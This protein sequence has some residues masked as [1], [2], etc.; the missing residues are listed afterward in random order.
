M[1]ASHY[2]RALE[3]ARAAGR[4]DVELVARARR[5]LREAGERAVSLWAWPAAARFFEDALELWPD[6]DPELGYIRLE[7]GR[8]RFNVDG[9]G[10]ELV[11]EGAEELIEAGDPELAARAAVT[12]GRLHWMVGDVE[13]QNRFLER[14]LALVGD[15]RDS[16]AWVAARTSQVAKTGFDG[17]F[18][19]AIELGSDVLLAAER[20]G[21]NDFRVRLLNL[22]GDARLALGDEGGFEDLA[23]SIAVATET[24]AHEHLHS[25]LNNLLAR[26]INLGRAKDARETY[27]RMQENLERY[28]AEAERRWVHGVGVE[29]AFSSGNWREASTLAD[30]YLA[31][32]DVSPSYLDPIVRRLRAVLRGTR[33]DLAGALDDS[34]KALED[35]RRS[36]DGQLVG[37]TL[38]GHAAILLLDRRTADAAAL[39]RE[40]LELENLVLNDFTL[41]DAAWTMHDVGLA[42]PFGAWLD[43]GPDLPWSRAARLILADD[44]LAAAEL[45]NEIYVPGEAYAR[46]RA[47]RQLV[48]GGRRAEADVELQRALAF[49]REVGATLYVREGEA[50]LAASA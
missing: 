11:R 8:A 49:W 46:L 45:M 44:F 40:A 12:A 3:Y 10:L 27:A 9:T 35:A 6:D 36:G 14:A 31:D 32:A 47:G 15:R 34:A 5:A 18:A 13:S 50:L 17:R 19:E 23:R 33:A 16:P 42:E 29:L 2:S 1:L 43:T 24:H 39:A 41:L 25:A 4:D 21:L 26:Q 37:P 30:T 28:P 7:C 48:D 22:R 38:V 20:L